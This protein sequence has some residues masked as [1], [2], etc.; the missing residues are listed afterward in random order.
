MA[1][2][3]ITAEEYKAAVEAAKWMA[4]DMSSLNVV[5]KR[6]A[7]V[8][9]ALAGFYRDVPKD[10][11]QLWGAC[12]SNHTDENN[13]AA[14]AT[15]NGLPVSPSGQ[16]DGEHFVDANKKVE[17]CPECGGKCQRCGGKKEIEIAVWDRI[18]GDWSTE[19]KPCPA[20]SGK[21]R[22]ER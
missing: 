16:V 18:A 15:R 11:C 21:G 17:P 19:T 13:K 8:L 14:I 9:L 7:R 3:P 12:E 22:G 5:Y 1:E 6:M 4:D 2:K 10:W 20:C